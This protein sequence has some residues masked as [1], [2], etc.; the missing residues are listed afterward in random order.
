MEEARNQEQESQDKKEAPAKGKNTTMAALCY[1]GILIL[2]PLLTEA[3]NDA[4]VKFHIKQGLILIIAGIITSVI[5]MI[6][7]LGWVAGPIMWIIL[8]IL[9]IIGLINALSGKESELPLIGK[10][11]AGLKI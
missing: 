11:G 9:F 4:F 7:F 5:L 2:I 3:K 1:F 6:P 10:Y 8:L